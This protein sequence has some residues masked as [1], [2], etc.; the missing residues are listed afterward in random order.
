MLHKFNRAVAFAGLSC[1][2]LSG[3]P[4]LAQD[5]E[6]LP[7]GLTPAEQA[8]IA[9]EPIRAIFDRMPPPS[10]PISTPAEYGPMEGILVSYIGSS[11]WK[12]ILQQMGAQITTV[13]DANIYVIAP[14]TTEANNARNGMITRGADPA[15]IFTYVRAL[16]SIWMRDYGPRYIY[17]GGI[18]S[19]VDH[20]YN[21]PRPSDNL[22]PGFWANTRGEMRYNIPLVH[23]GG[24][25]H[26][27]GLGDAYA[28]LLIKNENP[29]LSESQII[30]LWR[31]YQNLETELV[32]P[33]P[34]NV[35]ATQHI[36]MWLQI[37][38]D[39]KAI[40]STW[41][42]APGS[43]QAQIC[44]QMTTL[45]ES[46]GYTVYRTPAIGG[47]GQTHY[48]FTNVVMCNN[49]VL[50]P[51]YNN[52]SATY[53]QQA[54]AVWEQALPDHTIVQI[55]CDALATSAGVM[56]CI[57]MHVPANSAGENPAVWVT[58]PDT[59][60]TFEPGDMSILTWRTDDDKNDITSVDIQFSADGGATFEPLLS[61]LS[62]SGGTLWT[63]PDVATT[64]GVL[65]VI[66]QDGDGNTGFD[67]TD[68]PITINGDPGTLA[69]N[70]ADLNTSSASNSSAPGWGV[71]DGILTP[72]D[73]SAFVTFFSAADLRADLSAA[74][75][76][77][78]ASPGFGVPD[79]ILSATDFTAFIA[80]FNAGCPCDLPGCP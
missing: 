60:L 14:T 24:N 47:P 41:P 10:G 42:L 58:Y 30:D 70:P 35:D 67:D 64:N 13:G 73:F 40:V 44:D 19:I 27:S 63:V 15:R 69:C 31:D 53:S 16:N 62:D 29:S 68:F 20:T 7:K 54:R 39:D 52:I 25:Y 17:E 59:A 49:L 48:T 3:A 38:A 6:A 76:T 72:T 11:S 1:G 23:G 12:S 46:R 57:V 9:Q 2:L 43:T 74:S 37:I 45:L 78:T 34:A 61:G 77:N 28:T 26:L 80:Y 71:P 33:F 36:D 22:I 4:A 51:R 21:R 8:Q 50:V 55:T 56:H 5:G 18:R 65:R 66:A 32:A 79:G 75:A